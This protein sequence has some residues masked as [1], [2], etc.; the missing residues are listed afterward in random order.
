MTDETFTLMHL[1][2]CVDR[3]RK[4]RRLGYTNSSV[5]ICDVVVSSENAPLIQTVVN[6]LLKIAGIRG[7]Y[8]IRV[9]G[10]RSDNGP[11]AR[12]ATR[13][14]IADADGWGSG[15]FAHEVFKSLHR[16]KSWTKHFLSFED[17]WSKNVM[18]R[19][20]AFRKHQP[21]FQKEYNAWLHNAYRC[22]TVA[23]FQM[24]GELLAVFAESFGFHVAAKHIR[25]KWGDE[26]FA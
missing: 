15:C 18:P 8:R 26:R 10:C 13:K 1:F 11:G 20:T 17:A 12:A 2:I 16:N 19:D 23:H 21:T 22:P 24:Y 5:P 6:D 7:S 3:K 4:A 14:I 9:R 25:L